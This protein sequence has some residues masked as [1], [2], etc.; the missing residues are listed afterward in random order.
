MSKVIETIEDYIL[1][2]LSD[3]K[4]Q[5]RIRGKTEECDWHDDESNK[6]IKDNPSVSELEHEFKYWEY[7]IKED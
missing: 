5:F 2:L 4:I 7:R 1:A 3:N 6:F